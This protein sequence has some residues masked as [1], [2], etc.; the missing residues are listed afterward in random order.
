MCDRQN[1]IVCPSWEMAINP[2]TGIDMPSTS[3][4]FIMEW[5]AINQIPIWGFISQTNPHYI[6]IIIGFVRNISKH[7]LTHLW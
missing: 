4:P 1:W 6:S 5:M 2:L 3:I 7:G